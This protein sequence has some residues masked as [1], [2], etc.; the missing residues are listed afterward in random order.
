ME[1]IAA[2]RLACCAPGYGSCVSLNKPTV[3]KNGTHH[4]ALG[5]SG[6]KNSETDPSPPPPHAPALPLSQSLSHVSP[7]VLCW[8]PDAELVPHSCIVC[9]VPLAYSI[10][11]CRSPD[12]PSGQ[13]RRRLAVGALAFFPPRYTREGDRSR[14]GYLFLRTPPALCSESLIF[15]ISRAIL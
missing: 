12:Y 8:I 6:K 7:L 1:T 5:G 14:P 2:L 4:T 9:L 3:P 11:V 15:G 10:V 13:P